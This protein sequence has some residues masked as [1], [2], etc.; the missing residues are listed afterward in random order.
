MH[1]QW[2]AEENC[3]QMPSDDS[4]WGTHEVLEV[5]NHLQEGHVKEVG[6]G[7]QGPPQGHPKSD[8]IGLDGMVQQ[9]AQQSS[10]PIEASSGMVTFK[11]IIPKY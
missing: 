1:L 11:E 9:I 10:Q 2:F 6:Q 5:P 8:P 3:G 4:A 7:W